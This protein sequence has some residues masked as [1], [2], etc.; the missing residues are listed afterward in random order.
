MT[1]IFSRIWF[2]AGQ[3]PQRLRHE[4]RLKTHVRIAH[5]PLDLR[6]RHQRRDRVDHENVDRLAAHEHIGD[7]QRILAA[8][9]LGNQQIFNVD[10]DLLRVT[11]VD[12]MLGVDDRAPAALRLRIGDDMQTERGFSA[13]FGSENLDDAAGRNTSD[14][15]RKVER[16]RTRADDRNILLGR[17]RIAEAHDRPFAETLLDLADRNLKVLVAAAI[18][19]GGFVLFFRHFRTPVI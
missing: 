14:A 10:A 8:V 7:I 2:D 4:P 17:A 13:R 9:R 19:I 3:L 1:P 12:R 6:L 16:E 5:L 18:L 11:G 15:E